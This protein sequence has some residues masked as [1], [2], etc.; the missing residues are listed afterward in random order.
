LFNALVAA[1]PARSATF[2]SVGFR[3]A[4]T[5]RSL[6]TDGKAGQMP[7]RRLYMR[8]G[9]DINRLHEDSMAFKP[10]YGRDRAER[11]RA[12]RA[13]SAEKLKK[14]EEKAAQRKAER[15]AAGAPASDTTS[16]AD[17]S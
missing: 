1:L 14:K 13:R 3:E 11:D 8:V 2:G 15:D 10:N 5:S 12:A 16:D 9:F 6:Q 17:E 7:D 4:W